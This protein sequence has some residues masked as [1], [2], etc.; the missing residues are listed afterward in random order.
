MAG[1]FLGIGATTDTI[2]LVYPLLATFMAIGWAQNE[3]RIRH[4][5]TYIR[6]HL[7]CATPYLG[8]E[9]HVQKRREVDRRARYVVL[10][11]G[12]IFVFTQLVAIGMGVLNFTTTSVEWALLGVD[13]L[14]VLAVLWVVRLARR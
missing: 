6:E 13:I 12:G 8:W 3:L 4:V 7:E 14:A 10:S 9:T 2:A 1:V 11:H 5:A